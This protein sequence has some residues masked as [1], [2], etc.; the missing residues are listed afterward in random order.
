[1]EKIFIQKTFNYFVWSPLGRRV[2]TYRNF[3]L[4]VHFK[5]SALCSLILFPLFATGVNNTQVEL[6]A[7]FAAGDVDTGGK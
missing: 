6:V 5:V 2:N 1:M 3:C 4:Q 7:K